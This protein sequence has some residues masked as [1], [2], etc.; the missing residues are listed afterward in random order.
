M[1][2]QRGQ[3]MGREAGA[4]VA[5]RCAAVMLMLSGERQSNRERALGRPKRP[6]KHNVLEIRPLDLT[7]AR[8]DCFGPLAAAEGSLRLSD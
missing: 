5:I 1:S 3:A 4:L 2:P 7:A 8:G 6:A